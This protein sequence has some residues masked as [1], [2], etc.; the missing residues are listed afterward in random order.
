MVN[1]CLFRHPVLTEH[2]IIFIWSSVKL[3]R[4]ISG[5][6]ASTRYIMFTSWAD[7]QQNN[8]LKHTILEFPG[9]TTGGNSNGC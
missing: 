7:R 4:E 2:R 1:C 3:L 5:F 9:G 6:I 8:G